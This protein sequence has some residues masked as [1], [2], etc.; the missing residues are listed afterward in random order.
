[1][2][3]LPDY[4]RDS[5]RNCCCIRFWARQVPNSAPVPVVVHRQQ[6]VAIPLPRIPNLFAS[7]P[8]FPVL[9]HS[10]SSTKKH[11]IFLRHFFAI[12]CGWAVHSPNHPEP[13]PFRSQLLFAPV[14]R[15]PACRPLPDSDLHHPKDP[16]G[17]IH[18]A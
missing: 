9:V 17:L 3:P 15:F 14:D 16:P 11:R 1:R 8:S 7:N 5:W 13:I 6:A 12:S 10:L 18:S 2:P 4:P